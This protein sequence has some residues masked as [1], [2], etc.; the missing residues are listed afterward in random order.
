MGRLQLRAWEG[1]LLRWQ[2]TSARRGY[3]SVSEWIRHTLNRQADPDEQQASDVIYGRTTLE[4]GVRVVSESL[5][6]T[7]AVTLGVIVTGGVQNELPGEEGLA[8]FC[9]QMLFQGT[10]RRDALAI[11]RDLEAIGAEAGVLAHRDYTGLFLS[12][13]DEYAYPAL[14]LLGE[15]LLEPSF[16]AEDWD[17]ERSLRTQRQTLLA[18][19]QPGRY[20]R[21]QVRA[22]AWPE[23]PM[24]QDL[25]ATGE[26]TGWE[27][28]VAYWRRTLRSERLIVAAAGG[29]RHQEFA[30]QA[31]DVFWRLTASGAQS[32]IPP[33]R[34]AGVYVQE[35]APGDR[36]YF[37]CGIPAPGYTQP[38]RA[39]WQ[40]WEKVLGGG[41][42]SRLHRLLREQEPLVY[43]IRAE[44]Q[45]FGQGGMLWI[46]GSAPA[47]NVFTA[48]QAV[49]A[50]VY[51]LGADH[52]PVTE[53]ELTAAKTRIRSELLRGAA[54]LRAQMTRLAVDEMYTGRRIAITDRLAEV[55][56]LRQDT[57]AA[58]R[59]TLLDRLANVD[60][61]V[62]DPQEPTGQFA[63]DRAALSRFLVSF[64]GRCRRARHRR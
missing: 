52:A 58:L 39:A 53:E 63:K 23:H 60:L 1:D 45:S 10:A 11:A 61:G 9:S 18:R 27:E 37:C 25:L 12:V 64:R 26:R 5:P 46:E 30:A 29:I 34:Q 20:L 50:E 36:S 57:L 44:Y 14:D 33:A 47:G 35:V 54:D 38:E 4:N 42:S 51:R 41:V 16:P 3:R 6:A 13:M 48:V 59:F 8:H 56:A 7:R 49:L 2:E 31:N 43:G 55:E 15:L 22:A 62:V 21:E 19:E 28:G 40:I 17:A 24:G 32:A